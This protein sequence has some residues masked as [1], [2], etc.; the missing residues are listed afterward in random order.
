MALLEAPTWQGTR[1]RNWTSCPTTW[2]STC[3]SPRSPPAC[4][5]RRRMRRPSSWNQTSRYLRLCSV[6]KHVSTYTCPFID[7]KMWY[8]CDTDKNE[9]YNVFSPDRENTLCASIHWT[10]P[11]TST[12]SSPLEL[13]LPS[14]KRFVNFFYCCI[15]II[16]WIY[17]LIY[18]FIYFGNPSPSLYL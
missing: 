18:V 16:P 1:W 4:W 2:S 17:S 13:F 14:T 15:W 5:C 7:L 6:Y 9:I 12:A 11:R 10:V 8:Y 3:W